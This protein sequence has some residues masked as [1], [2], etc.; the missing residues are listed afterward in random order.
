MPTVNRVA[1]IRNGLQAKHGDHWSQRS[2]AKRLGIHP[3]TLWRIEQGNREPLVTLA[4]ALARDLGVTVE[5]LGFRRVP[6][7]PTAAPSSDG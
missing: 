1:E 7:S 4:V 3:N 6:V 5:Q 2:V